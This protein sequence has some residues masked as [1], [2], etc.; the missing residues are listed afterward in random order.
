MTYAVKKIKLSRVYLDNANPRHDPIENELEI[1]AYLIE[2]ENVKQLARHISEVGGTSP[3]E[4]IAVFPHPKIKDAFIAAEGNR[5]VCAF[6][7]LADPDKANTEANKKYFRKLAANMERVPNAF[8]MVVFE[9]RKES[10]S[11]ISLRHEGEQNG[12]GTRTWDARQIT[13]FNAQSEGASNPN[14]QASL[15]IEYAR[16][17]HLL[18]ADRIDELSITT[19]TRYLSNPVFRHVLGLI[20]TKTLTISVAVEE[21]NRVVIKFLNDALDPASEVG[22]RSTAA[23]RKA[24]GEKLRNDGVAPS[25]YGLTPVDLGTRQPRDSSSTEKG[26]EAVLPSVRNN[27]SPDKR[28]SVIPSDFSARITDKI[29]KRLYDELRAID[30]EQYSFSATYLLRAVIEQAATIYLKKNGRAAPKE[31]HQRLGIV[32][33]LLSADGFTERELKSLRVMANDKDSRYS[34][35]SIGHFVHGGMIPTKTYAIKAWDSIEHVLLA[36]LRKI[37]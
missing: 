18:K 17:E 24:Y 10:R 21:F 13:R 22:S 8:E 6:K 15:L 16:R 35:D 14:I 1:I 26:G 2:K 5:R 32:A 9:D 31:L 19:L 34:P 23:D 36:L 37:A 4:R 20:D 25:N 7:L 28:R 11:W 30:A 27:P 12:I 29:L 33:D 3:L